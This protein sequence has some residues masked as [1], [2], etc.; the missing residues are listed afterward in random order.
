MLHIVLPLIYLYVCILFVHSLTRSIYLSLSVALRTCVSFCLIRWL[1]LS[2]SF[3]LSRKSAFDER[4]SR[5]LARFRISFLFFLLLKSYLSFSHSSCSCCSLHSNLPSL[6]AQSLF[7]MTLIVRLFSLTLHRSPIRSPRDKQILQ[8]HKHTKSVTSTL[9]QI[10]N[11]AFCVRQLKQQ[12]TKSS[13]FSHPRN[14][15][16]YI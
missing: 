3:T 1:S 10:A 16:P 9:N 11:N 14:V 12:H 13:L 7:T 2:V 15:R 5:S 4:M 8:T 6:S